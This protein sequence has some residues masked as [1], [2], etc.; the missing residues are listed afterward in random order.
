MGKIIFP[1]LSPPYY[2]LVCSIYSELQ[3]PFVEE[4]NDQG[5]HGRD[6]G[7]LGKQHPHMVASVFKAFFF[8]CVGWKCV[9]F[10]WHMGVHSLTNH[11]ILCMDYLLAF[12]MGSVTLKSY[13]FD[14]MNV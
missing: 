13:I 8:V 14:I 4:D 3:A 5:L 12:D 10:I 1:I 7:A 6:L 11:Y 2:I 9:S